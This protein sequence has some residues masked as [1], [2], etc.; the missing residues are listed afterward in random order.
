MMDA[1]ITSDTIKI[2]TDWIVETE[3]ISIDKIEVDLGMNTFIEEKIL[4]AMQE[5]N[6]ILGDR[7]IK[8]NTEITI[9][10][11]ITVE[12]EVG[13]GLERDHFQEV[14]IIEGNDRSI[15][16]SRSRSGSRA[17]TNWDRYYVL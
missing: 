11:K 1:A 16:N 8:E 9:G 4:E 10:L 5:H 15:S 3:E 12:I 13:I 14:L 2:D 6:K 17:G 7:T